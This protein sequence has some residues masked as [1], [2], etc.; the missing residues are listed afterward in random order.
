MCAK[1]KTENINCQ[2]Y[3]NKLSVISIECKSLDTFPTL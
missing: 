3:R 1:H 2:A